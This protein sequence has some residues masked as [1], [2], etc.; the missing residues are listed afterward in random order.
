MEQSERSR[1]THLHPFPFAAKR[2]ENRNDRDVT[3]RGWDYRW[4]HKD[5]LVHE[6][7]PSLMRKVIVTALEDRPRL[8]KAV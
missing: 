7:L 6:A 4:V 3:T 8:R 1:G 5:E 2:V